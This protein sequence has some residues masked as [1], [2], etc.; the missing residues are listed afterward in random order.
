[1]VMHQPTISVD[2]ETAQVTLARD[3]LGVLV[4]H[5]PGHPWHVTVA[6]GMA[7]VRNYGLSHDC[8]FGLHINKLGGPDAVKK[9]AVLA[10]GEFLERH[11][12]RRGRFRREDYPGVIW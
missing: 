12:A 6:S 1:M 9:G 4:D 10:G 3:I 2:T 5:Y 8:G 11:N 7:V